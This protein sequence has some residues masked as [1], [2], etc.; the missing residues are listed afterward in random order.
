MGAIVG[1]G[2]THG[3]ALFLEQV[4]RQVAQRTDALGFCD[5]W[6]TGDSNV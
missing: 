3:P 4:I 2:A 5:L 6:V 1:T